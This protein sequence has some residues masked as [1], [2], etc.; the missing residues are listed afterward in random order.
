MSAERALLDELLLITG[1]AP[2][3]ETNLRAEPCETL[4]ATDA[5]PSDA[6]G[7]SASIHGR[8]GSP[9]TIWPRTKESTFASIGKAKNHR[10]TCALHVQLLHR[11]L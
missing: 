6:G 5:S 8:T 10:A 3:L 9:C 7:C 1:L 2:L 11:L 4:F